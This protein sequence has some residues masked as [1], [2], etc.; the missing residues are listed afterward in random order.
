MSPNNLIARS[1]DLK[2]LRNEGFDIKVSGT[3]L[4]VRGIPYVNAEKVIKLGTLVTVLSLQQDVT[5][6]PENHVAYFIGEYPCTMQGKQLTNIVIGTDSQTLAEG[7]TVGF[8]LSSRPTHGRGYTD[9]HEKMTTYIKMLT[10][11]AKALDEGVTANTF[12]IVFDE[13]ASTPFKYL[14]TASSRAGIDALTPK[15]AME[16]IAIVGVG[17][18]GSYVLDLVAK[19]HVRNV[20]LFDDAAFGQHNAFRSPGAP[21]VEDLKPGT[22]KVAHYERVYSAMRNGIVTHPYR[23][24]ETNV[25]ELQAMQFVFICIDSGE[26]KERMFA[27]LEKA[28]VPFIDVGMGVHELSMLMRVAVPTYEAVRMVVVVVVVIVGVLMGVVHDAVAVLVE[29]VGLK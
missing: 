26:F 19:T 28:T 3:H 13:D 14:D 12:P 27:E 9:Y 4:L 1:P 21:G 11:E 29:V 17:G 18:T 10:N 23:I 16:N 15:L 7:I 2:R 8:T 24:D 22:K 25:H 20:H 5:V 6:K